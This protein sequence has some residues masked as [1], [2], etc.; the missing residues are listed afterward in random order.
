MFLITKNQSNGQYEVE[1]Q[2]GQQVSQVLGYVITYHSHFQGH[3]QE[4]SHHKT[5]TNLMVP[6]TIV[7]HELLTQPAEHTTILLVLLLHL[8][9]LLEQQ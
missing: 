3:R 5:L 2:Q 9:P 1:L 6:F 7:F 4:L 8:E